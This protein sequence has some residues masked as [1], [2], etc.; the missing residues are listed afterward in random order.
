MTLRE[1]RLGLRLG[2]YGTAGEGAEKV[3]FGGSLG[4]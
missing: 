4:D 1:E 2:F 3:N